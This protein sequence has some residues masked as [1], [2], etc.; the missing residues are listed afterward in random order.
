VALGL[1]WVFSSVAVGVI[2]W[3]LVAIS[4]RRQDAVPGWLLLGLTML[5]VVAAG[6]VASNRRRATT[7]AFL[8]LAAGGFVIIGI[9][10]ALVASARGD[11]IAGD[12]LLIGGVPVVGGLVCGRRRTRRPGCAGAGLVAAGRRTRVRPAAA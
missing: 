4:D 8:V 2:G 6:A 11:S 12:L 5:G 1:A 7:L 3:L 9:A 10:A